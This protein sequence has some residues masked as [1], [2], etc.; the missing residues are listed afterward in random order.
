MKIQLASLSICLILCSYFSACNYSSHRIR[1][2]SNKEYSKFDSL[3]KSDSFKW[4][5]ET[6][7]TKVMDWVLDENRRALD[8]VESFPDYKTDY[9][10]ILSA[11]NDKERIPYPRIMGDKIYNFWQDDQHPRGILRRTPIKPFNSG[12]PK[13]ETVLDIDKLSKEEGI[14]WSYSALNCLPPQYRHCFIRLSPGGKDAGDIREFDMQ[15]KSFV[16]GGFHF[17]ESKSSIRWLDK[18]TLLIANGIGKSNQTDSGYPNKL[19]IL[20]RGGN[21][22]KT[23]SILSVSDSDIAIWPMVFYRKDRLIAL[24]RKKPSF[25]KQIY[26]LKDSKDNWVPLSIPSDATVETIFDN[27]LVVLL[28]KDWNI[29]NDSKNSNRS[30][31][32]KQYA[33]GSLLLWD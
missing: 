14:A 13:W 29:S 21:L 31:K 1:A 18:N 22:D 23:P 2:N 19:Q 20:K 30:I 25:F 3:R 27:K 16:K 8:Y 17:S 5:E 26:Y 4:L 10:N 32:P 24:A 28:R 6:K 33:A 9:K 15:K 11:L 12:N 7:S